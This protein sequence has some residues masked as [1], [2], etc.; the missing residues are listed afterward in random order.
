M[1]MK[2]AGRKQ[3]KDDMVEK[4]WVSRKGEVSQCISLFLETSSQSW[5]TYCSDMPAMQDV[6]QMC[7]FMGGWEVRTPKILKDDCG[8]MAF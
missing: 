2:E 4:G 7:G 8:Q 6:K 3:E 1:E 5:P